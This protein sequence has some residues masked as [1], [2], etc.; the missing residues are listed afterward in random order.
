[1]KTKYTNIRIKPEIHKKLRKLAKAR[2]WSLGYL[3]ASLI[4]ED[5]F[6]NH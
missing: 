3:I 5:P 2:G 4:T 1:M 6:R